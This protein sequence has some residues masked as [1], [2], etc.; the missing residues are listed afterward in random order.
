MTVSPLTLIK[1]DKVSDSTDY[2]DALPVNMYAVNREILGANGYMLVY[3]GLT[4][5]GTGAGIDRAA[6][7]NERFSDQ[8]RVSGTSLISVAADGTVATLGTISGSEQAAMPYSFNTQCV[9]ADGKMF[10]YDPTNGLNEV[11]D[12]DLGDPIDGVWID[13]YYFLTDGEYVYHT[14]ITDESSIDPLKFATAEF[15]PDPSNGVG[16]TE[17]N[18][19]MVF[20]RYTIEYFE[21]VATENFA[22]QRI[23]SRAVKIG[24]V[25]THA[26]CETGGHWY[27]TGGRKHDAV[28]V[29]VVDVGEVTKVS[30][31]EIDKILATYTEPELIDMRMEARTEDGTVFILVHLPNE[32]LCFNETI[33]VGFEDVSAAW[34]ILKTGTADQAYRAINGVHDA[35]TAKWTYGDKNDSTIGVLDNTKCTQYGEIAEWLLFTPFF[36]LDGGSIDEIE[37]ETIPGNTSEDDAKVAFSITYNGLTYSQEWWNMYGEPSDYGHRFYLRRL[38]LV[39]EWAGFKFRGTTTS[40]MSFALLTVTHA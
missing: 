5:L 38:G 14:D 28:G 31:R 23:D 33:A 36:T 2:R 19:A 25:A 21:D 11:T 30:T 34:S 8:Y 32:T 7:Y 13:G 26:K 18:K 10:L 20:G 37:L 40:R 15:M 24:I 9:I 6:N 1:G 29:Y 3:P 12:T 16:K 4:Q 22:F 27:I 35:R 39:N 17:D